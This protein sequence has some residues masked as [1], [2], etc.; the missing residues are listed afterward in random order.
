MRKNVERMA[1]NRK[2]GQRL[3]LSSILV[4]LSV[5]CCL[6][7]LAS[8][9]D[10]N[11]L[12]LMRDDVLSYFSPLKGKVVSV[13]NGMAVINI[14]E[15]SNVKK[16]MR[17]I[18]FREGAP[19]LHPVTKAPIGTLEAV[20]GKAEIKE[21]GHDT[22][23]AVILKGDVKVS[24]K[25]RIS[26]TGVR[27][28]FYQGKNVDWSLGD[29]YY[30][31]IK[32]TGRFE[33]VDTAIETD[34]D[35]EVMAEAKRLN[36]DV[37]LILSAKEA[38]G[39]TML[40]HRLLWADNALKFAEDEVR[41]AVAF[42]KELRFGE[43]FFGP[44]KGDVRTF[45]DLPFGVRLIT[46]GDIDGDGKAELL[47]STG[48]DIRLYS[49]GAAGDLSG[50]YEIKGTPKD[51]HIW[52]DVLDINRD[53]KDEVILTLMKDDMVVSRIYEFK[54]GK[55]FVLWEGDVF[56]KRI[57]NE[58]IAQEYER[59]EGY[60]GA[61]FKV[62]WDN[63]YKKG[64][65][66]SIPRGVNIYDFIF[67]NEPVGIDSQRDGKRLALA[68]DDAGHLNLYDEGIRI[69]RSKGDYGGFQT[70]FK[71]VTP[72]IMVERGEWAVKD[73]LVMQNREILVIKRIPLVGMAKGIGYSKSQIRSLWWTGV[74]MEERTIIDDI[75]GKALDYTIAD[76]RIIVLDMPMLGIKFKN[77]LKGEN[78]IG[79]ALY[80]YPLKGR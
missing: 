15:R 9:A 53:G 75:P 68:Y 10:D 38:A 26:E 33:I 39:D 51:D 49:S 54:D 60:K 62:A 12:S 80:I 41:V 20:I 28:L 77:I 61:V 57:G 5:I 73:R 31:L 30:R 25:V 29:S 45:V 18:V 1:Q 13:N 63:G 14:G 21:A 11:P 7:P 6:V 40:K 37:V 43:E 72:T 78:P 59:G 76:N 67:I 3:L 79:T 17:F 71:R 36:A 8:Y 64:D 42:M 22:S 2:W 32:E 46:A 24:D 47:M 50:L 27:M 44:Q 66:V 52:L 35:S 69:W 55:F 74:S 56:L 16:G 19:F 65:N 23:T 70:T 58:L 48:S 4:L 34:N